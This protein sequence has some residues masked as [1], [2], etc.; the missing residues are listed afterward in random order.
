MNII[1]VIAA[2]TRHDLSRGAPRRAEPI[3]S[4]SWDDGSSSPSPI[5]PPDALRTPVEEVPFFYC[6]ISKA[7]EKKRTTALLARVATP[8]VVCII[9]PVVYAYYNIRLVCTYYSSS[10]VMDPLPLFLPPKK[11]DR[12]PSPR[13]YFQST[14]NRLVLQ[15]AYLCIAKPS[16]EYPYSQYPSTPL[17]LISGPLPLPA[18]SKLERESMHCPRGRRW[19]E[20]IAPASLPR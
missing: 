11:Y 5:P 17:P 6:L 12:D 16:R 14:P 13:G 15:Y 2:H 20:Y 1:C 3:P 7:K 19:F 18:I 8:R 9:P 10:G 4:L